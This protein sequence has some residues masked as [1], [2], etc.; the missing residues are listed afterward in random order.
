MWW[1]CYYL[2][3]SARMQWVYGGKRNVLERTLAKGRT[4]LGGVG[5]M[6]MYVTGSLGDINA[7]RHSMSFRSMAAI[8]F[9]GMSF[10]GTKH[11]QSIQESK[12]S[13]CRVEIS[14]QVS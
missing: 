13:T 12:Y 11:H 1:R 4:L 3:I 14:S 5:I 6:S 2:V 7:L 10:H 8:S 9:H